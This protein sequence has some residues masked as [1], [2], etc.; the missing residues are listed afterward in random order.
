VASV[1]ATL[2]LSL[3]ERG[4][5]EGIGMVAVLFGVI[6]VLYTLARW[7][8]LDRRLTAEIEKR[9]RQTTDLRVTTFEEV[10]LLNEGYGVVEVFVSETSDI[11]HKSIAESRLRARSMVVLAVDRA[12]RVVAAPDGET[13]LLPGDRLICYGKVASIGGIADRRTAAPPEGAPHDAHADG[14]LRR[15]VVER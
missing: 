6:A 8:G 12:G 4:A 1:R 2:I 15:H 13:V 10:L 5:A 14:E 7:Q 9:L 3:G 11:A